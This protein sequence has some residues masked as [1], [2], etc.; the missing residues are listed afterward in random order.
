MRVH[1]ADFSGII[2]LIPSTGEPSLLASTR[3]RLSRVFTG[4]GLRWMGVSER[5]KRIGFT[6]LGDKLGRMV[7]QGERPIYRFL[8]RR[9]I[10]RFFFFFFII[11][12]G[13][14]IVVDS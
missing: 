7:E 3:A 6:F 13:K 9:G 8:S 14:E 12:T 5:M 11:I 10:D 4:S 2:V 1:G